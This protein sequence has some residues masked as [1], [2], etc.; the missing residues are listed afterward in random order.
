MTA[1]LM[2][3][4]HKLLSFIKSEGLMEKFLSNDGND[5]SGSG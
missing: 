1:N 5:S 4:N 3:E 2:N